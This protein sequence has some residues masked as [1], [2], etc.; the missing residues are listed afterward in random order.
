M[1]V[2]P[3]SVYRESIWFKF[4]QMDTRQQQRVC[5]KGDGCPSTAAGM[6]VMGWISVSASM[7]N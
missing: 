1:A 5:R 4:F 2:I 6:T 7:K 3:D